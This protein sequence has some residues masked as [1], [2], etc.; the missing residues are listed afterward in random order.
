MPR[1]R[2]ETTTEHYLVK[3]ETTGHVPLMHLALYKPGTPFA[4]PLVQWPDA[5]VVAVLHSAV[6]D[7]PMDQWLA[8]EVMIAFR[9][10]L[11]DKV[12]LVEVV[13]PT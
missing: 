5:Q 13:E 12:A 9:K 7:K 4:I 10:H 2:Q 8:V 11:I 3:I 1:Y 6:K